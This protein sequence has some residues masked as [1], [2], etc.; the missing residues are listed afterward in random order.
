MGFWDPC[1]KLVYR[2]SMSQAQPG[3]ASLRASMSQSQ[4]G[5]ASHGSHMCP[6]QPMMVGSVKASEQ[7]SI[8]ARNVLAGEAHSSTHIAGPEGVRTSLKQYH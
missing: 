5:M 6:I 4:P 8:G 1:N 7:G 2:D 3:M